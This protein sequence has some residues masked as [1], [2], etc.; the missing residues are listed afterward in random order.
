MKK[1]L[2]PVVITLLITFVIYLYLKRKEIGVL[3]PTNASSAAVEIIDEANTSTEVVNQNP[4]VK[5]TQLATK[6]MYKNIDTILPYN[7]NDSGT[8]FSNLSNYEKNILEKI[9]NLYQEKLNKE[10]ENKSIEYNKSYYSAKNAHLYYYNKNIAIASLSG[11]DPQIYHIA[12]NTISKEPGFWSRERLITSKNYLIALKNTGEMV[13]FNRLTGKFERIIEPFVLAKNELF[14]SKCVDE[15]LCTRD[16]VVEGDTLVFGIY[17][18]VERDA[19]GIH[20]NTKLREIR[21]LLK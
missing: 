4:E 11:G 19:Q 21:V 12:E 2:I 5:P 15:G 3:T 7:D 13:Y 6:D 16:V 17:K 10:Q 1:I 14:Y 8:S 9:S 20:T 18:S